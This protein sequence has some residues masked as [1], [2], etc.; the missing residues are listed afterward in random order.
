MEEEAEEDDTMTGMHQHRQRVED[1]DRHVWVNDSEV[2]MLNKNIEVAVGRGRKFQEM[3]DRM[4]KT[5]HLFSEVEM[6]SVTQKLSEYLDMAVELAR[7]RD[8]RIAKLKQIYHDSKGAV[9]LAKGRSDFFVQFESMFTDRDPE[10]AEIS[11]IFAEV[12]QMCD[13]RLQAMMR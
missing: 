10:Y 12:N 5:P 8:K 11:G 7:S 9:D 2:I 1:E 3:L 13:E 4:Q 6:S